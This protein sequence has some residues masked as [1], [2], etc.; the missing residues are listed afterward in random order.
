MLRLGCKGV[1]HLPQGHRIPC[2]C[3]AQTV[4][5]QPS[6]SP[7]PPLGLCHPA[8]R[9]PWEELPTPPS[10]PP[11]ASLFFQ[12]ALD[13]HPRLGSHSPDDPCRAVSGESVY[14][15]CLGQ[16][17]RCWDG[18]GSG[19]GREGA[20]PRGSPRLDAQRDPGSLPGCGQQRAVWG[21]WRCLQGV[22]APHPRWTPALW[23]SHPNTTAQDRAG[24]QLR[25]PES[26]YPDLS[27]QPRPV[28][29]LIPPEGLPAGLTLGR[30]TIR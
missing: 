30:G 24:P 16:G 14:A 18:R 21:S 23:P 2:T 5:S 6:I 9:P 15:Q 17:W 13:A 28:G 4:P 7:P 3:P 8:G 12:V 22:R 1:P 10:L 19:R 29:P 20:E 27:P 26:S 11:A 25:P